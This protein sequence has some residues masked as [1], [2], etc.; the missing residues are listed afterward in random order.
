LV[1]R[2]PANRLVASTTVTL[3]TRATGLGG[4]AALDY[5]LCFPI[6]DQSNFIT[7][8]SR[9]AKQHATHDVDAR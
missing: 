7:P 5:Y 6:L 3:A 4:Y 2:S 1:A 9:L 8:A